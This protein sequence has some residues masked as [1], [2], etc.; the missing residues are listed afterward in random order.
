MQNAIRKAIA[1]CKILL[2]NGYDAYVINAPLQEQ[3]L[4]KTR[5][6]SVDIA[7]A[8]EPDADMLAKLFPRIRREAEKR[9][10]AEME[11][12]GL[13]FR[14]YPL[15]IADVA[16]PELSILRITPCMT[17][18]MDPK[19]RLQLR[20][21]GFGSPPPS[22][23]AYD[24]FKNFGEGAV[25]LTGL[26]DETLRHN[27]LLAIRALRFAA[28]FDIPIEP[29]TW[30]AI[31]RA[32]TRV[33]DYVALTDIMNEWRKVAA[34]S[35]YRF[36]RLLHDAHI[37]QGL[38]P[39]VAALSCIR[40]QRNDDGEVES[41]FDHTLNCVRL[42]PEENFHYD[43]LGAM[44]MLF[45]D[46]GKLYTG[47]F[48][49]GQWTFYQHHRVGAKV[50]RKILRRLH[51]NAEDID[52][53]CHLVNNHMRFHFMLT[54]RGIRRFKSLD[55]YPRLIAMT[56]A[57][58]CARDGGCTS[59]N[60]NMKYLDRAETPEQMLEP[61]LNGNEIMD[62]TNLAPGP[63]VGIIR[64]ALLQ[65][66]IAGDVTD[67]ESALR[68][69]RSHARRSAKQPPFTTACTLPR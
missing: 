1:I 29:N 52:L 7:I 9:A 34:E 39:E 27:Y 55:E 4:K 23:D 45:H 66:Q 61:L 3:L 68:F 49:D 28:N 31:V 41:V 44:A 50:T 35:L 58:M 15:E 32:A 10:L 57:D 30:L 22:G 21:T 26:P 17:S 13:T 16:H 25:Q 24:G 69:V 18:L 2:R 14:F 36:V 60:H 38:I 48:F 42:Y 62:A 54:D 59:F 67:R 19:T 64:E 65:A 63:Q 6:S 47:E 51:F 20:L 46:V 53:L 12:N 37:L 43:W 5:Q 8:C 11:E 33:L 56:R 40:Q